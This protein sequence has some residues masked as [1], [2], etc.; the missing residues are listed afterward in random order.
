MSLNR[1]LCLSI[2]T[3]LQVIQ[4]LFEHGTQVQKSLLASTMEG[5]VLMLSKQVYACR[6]VQKVSICKKKGLHQ[7]WLIFIQALDCIL[8]EQQTAFVRE[9]E[10]YF[11]QCVKDSNGNHVSIL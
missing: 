11:M 6:V 4:K 8:P 1:A 9:L 7:S 10:P 3:R 2:L 5:N